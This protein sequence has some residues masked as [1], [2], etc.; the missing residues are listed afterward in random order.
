MHPPPGRSHNLHEEPESRIRGH[1]TSPSLNDLPDELLEQIARNLDTYTTRRE[2]LN[3]PNEGRSSALHAYNFCLVSRKFYRIGKPFLYSIF[4][5]DN[6][7]TSLRN[8]VSRLIRTPE[9]LSYVRAVVIGELR[10][11]SVTD[12]ENE[13][14]QELRAACTEVSD[15]FNALSEKER[16]SWLQNLERLDYEAQIAL[17]LALSPNLETVDLTYGNFCSSG[18]YFS[19]CRRLISWAIQHTPPQGEHGPLSSLRHFVFR[20]PP[21]KTYPGD[22]RFW[23]IM[24]LPSLRKLELYYLSETRDGFPYWIEKI[25]NID[26]LV[27]RP[28]SNTSRLFKPVLQACRELKSVTYSLDHLEHDGRPFDPEGFLHLYEL[29]IHHKSLTDLV[30]DCNIPYETRAAMPPMP[31]LQDF[32]K[33]KRLHIRGTFLVHNFEEDVSLHTMELT[34]SIPRPYGVAVRFPNSLDHLLLECASM[35]QSHWRS[36]VTLLLSIGRS[37]DNHFPHLRTVEAVVPS[38]MWETS[39]G[40]MDEVGSLASVASAM[41]SSHGIVGVNVCVVDTTPG[42][43]HSRTYSFRKDT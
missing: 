22:H 38:M 40:S 34:D 17:L 14:V 11:S 21:F 30:L 36:F 15:K 6:D 2:I 39:W 18:F 25:S 28:R 19:W 20:E 8:G 42:Q 32:T 35:D 4:V 33:L 41:V 43:E 12:E 13:G 1:V 9:L 3:G 31:D 24:M 27:F 26:T 10:D 7:P 16:S 29:R 23:E 5:N 37:R